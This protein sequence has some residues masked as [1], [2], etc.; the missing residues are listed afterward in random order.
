MDNEKTLY[1]AGI[2]PGMVIF[3][4][5][6]ETCA[7]GDCAN[8]PVD[9]PPPKTDSSGVKGWIPFVDFFHFWFLFNVLFTC[10]GWL[11]WN[12]TDPF[13]KS[14]S[15]IPVLLFWKIFLY[16]SYLYIRNNG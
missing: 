14:A 11:C 12:E 1:Q 15:G 16:L 13:I 6:D 8:F 2:R 10:R 5:V 4:W 7:E 3:A 9:E